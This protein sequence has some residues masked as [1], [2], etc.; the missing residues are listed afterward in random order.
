MYNEEN[1]YDSCG[2]CE[3]S[4][5][6]TVD[7]INEMENDKK[8]GIIDHYK[9]LLMSEPEFIGIKNVCSGK[10]LNVI[11]DNYYNVNNYSLNKKCYKINSEQ[12]KIF[13]NMYSELNLVNNYDI[14]NIVVKKLFDLIYV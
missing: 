12:C 5:E 10:I 2:D 9:N 8:I 1:D 11:Y 6:F 3:L 13:D 7:V 14:Y 4:N